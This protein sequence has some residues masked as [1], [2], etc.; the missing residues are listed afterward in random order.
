MGFLDIGIEPLGR[1]LLEAWAVKGSLAKPDRGRDLA[2][3]FSASV[4]ASAIPVAGLPHSVPFIDPL[5][6]PPAVRVPARAL[7]FTRCAA[8]WIA[9]RLRRQPPFGQQAWHH[10]PSRRLLLPPLARRAT[11]SLEFLRAGCAMVSALN[12][13]RSLG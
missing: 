3:M 4:T 12:T 7:N 11:G 2:V 8:S 1:R 10:F 13:E 9:I 6:I 5:S